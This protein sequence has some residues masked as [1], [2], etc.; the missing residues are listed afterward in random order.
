[1]AS[2]IVAANVEPRRP[3]PPRPHRMI[4]HV[5]RLLSHGCG[6]STQARRLASMLRR[7]GHDVQFLVPGD[8]HAAPTPLDEVPIRPVAV[9]DFSTLHWSLQALTRVCRARHLAARIPLET[10]VVITSQPEFA[11]A[12][13]A[14]CAAR[15]VVLVVHSSQLLYAA[16]EAAADAERPWHRR[17]SFRVNARLLRKH[18]RAGFV[19]ASAVAFN[20]VMTREVVA[21]AYELPA[22]RCHLVPPT[23]DIER[24]KPLEAGLRLWHR[25]EI[26]L[27]P[28]AFVLCWTGRMADQKN[29]ELLIDAVAHVREHVAAVLLV[30]D[31]PLRGAWQARV[32][33]LG[34]GDRIRFLG[35][36]EHVERFLQVADAFVLPSRVEAFGIAVIEAMACGLPCVVL[37]HV[38][39]HIYSGAADAVVDGETGFVLD[40]D[41]PARLA[42]RL[43]Q[44]STEAPLRQ[45]MGARGRR[46]VIER[47]AL[48][49][50][51]IQLEQIVDGLFPHD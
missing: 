22:E 43:V 48:G 42:E 27:E 7:R 46:R 16:T 3:A 47:Y 28:N 50:D 4:W 5:P 19:A 20:S 21:A 37:G 41:D 34:L 18:E 49:R 25:M 30:G 39:G 40:G 45:L 15:P 10:E 44:L 36:Q 9:P 38:P 29:L 1:M 24:F 31:G 2:A 33:R 12:A 8:P 51:A 17:L 14:A 26:G 35:M 11:A 23:V 32:D 6:M 13:Q